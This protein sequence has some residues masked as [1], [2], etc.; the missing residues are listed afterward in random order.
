M[1]NFTNSRWPFIITLVLVTANIVTLTLL[2]TN[3]RPGGKHA[4]APPL[5]E[6]V[7]EFLS[8]ELKLDS[9]QKENYREL[10]DEHRAQVRPIRDS[11]RDAKDAFFELLKG[12]T[13]D[14]VVSAANHRIGL[15]EERLNRVTYTHFS[16]LRKVCN[17]E[18]QV[19]FDQIIHDVLRQMAPQRQ[20]GPPPPRQDGPG[21]LHPGNGNH[22]PPPPG[23]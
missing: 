13:D 9:A 18:Q 19:K 17:P 12:N 22:P 20:Q 23:E 14:S 5:N 8:R 15:L 6:D 21:G 1:K 2:W 16:K 10:R 3:N 4:M 11:I 7:F